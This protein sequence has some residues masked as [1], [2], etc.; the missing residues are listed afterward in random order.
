MSDSVSTGQVINVKD[1]AH[2]DEILDKAGPKPILALSFWA[3]W[4]E[5]C[6][7][8]DPVFSDLAKSHPTFQFMQI[9]A[10][11]LP[12]VSGSFEVEAVPCF[13]FL[14]DGEI[15]DRVDG[16][17]ASLLTR[18]AQALEKKA[19]G[20]AK[21]GRDSAL[22]AAARAAPSSSQVA[23]PRED[24]NTRLGKLVARSPVMVFI[25]GS[26]S[27]P[28]CGFSRQLVAL[29]QEKQVAFDYFDILEDEEVRQG[30]KTFSDWP[31]YPQLYVRG[32]LQGGLDIV[33]ELVESGELSKMIQVGV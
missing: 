25:K 29:L 21:A 28:R 1:E 20:Q 19:S 2:F 31:T 8:M 7:D 15:L 27:T 5:Q 14:R 16:A 26:P 17:N 4:A 32:E 23:E 11:A 10:E 24:L 33:K 22:D 12:E 13:I 3:P 9:E 6:K 18:T 30:L